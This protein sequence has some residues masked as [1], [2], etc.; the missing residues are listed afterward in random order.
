MGPCPEFNSA[1]GAGVKTHSRLVEMA[2][3]RSGMRRPMREAGAAP[4]AIGGAAPSSSA[5]RDP[6]TVREGADIHGQRGQRHRSPSADF[7]DGHLVVGAAPM[8]A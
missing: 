7:A 8:R 2:V 3:S 4:V 5:R 6:P 1:T